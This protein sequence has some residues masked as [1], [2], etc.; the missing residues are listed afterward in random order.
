MSV[1]PR[2]DNG[3]PRGGGAASS[4]AASGHLPAARLK[5]GGGAA[6]AH[7]RSD[8]LRGERAKRQPRPSGSL[9]TL[10]VG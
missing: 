3:H 7:A 9:S 8:Q 4:G 2:A 1:G 10:N 5:G 6:G